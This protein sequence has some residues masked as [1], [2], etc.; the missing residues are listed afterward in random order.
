[1]SKKQCIKISG[2]GLKRNEI[3][4]I[5]RIFEGNVIIQN[6]LEFFRYVLQLETENEKYGLS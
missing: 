5:S 3:L 6:I 4:N 2:V 1:M